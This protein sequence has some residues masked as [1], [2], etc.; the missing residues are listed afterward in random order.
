MSTHLHIQ[1]RAIPIALIQR[2]LEARMAFSAGAKSDEECGRLCLAYA[3]ATEELNRALSGDA[4][5]G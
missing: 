5:A 1:G 3:E 2:Y 4:C